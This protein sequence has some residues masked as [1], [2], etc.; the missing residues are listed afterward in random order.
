MKPEE[1]VVGRSYLRTDDE[2][3]IYQGYFPA[4][5]DDKIPYRFHR[6]KYMGYSYWN[7]EQVEKLLDCSKDYLQL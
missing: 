3:V 2:K 4:T 5:K 6:P 7:K 1:L